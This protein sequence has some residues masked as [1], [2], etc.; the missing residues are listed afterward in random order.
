MADAKD[1]KEDTEGN[2]QKGW[3]EKNCKRRIAEVVRIR[4]TS[5]VAQ[6]QLKEKIS[7]KGTVE[8]VAG[9][10]TPGEF[11]TS[12]RTRHE[13]QRDK[14]ETKPPPEINVPT[15]SGELLRRS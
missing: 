2:M 14:E 9:R 10:F 8:S 4:P 12:W 13:Y 1:K 7:N 3:I 15:Q 5:G 6:G 11:A